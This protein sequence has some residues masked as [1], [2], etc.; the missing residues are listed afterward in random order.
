MEDANKIKFA[1]YLQDWNFFTGEKALLKRH[2]RRIPPLD[3]SIEMKGALFCPECSAPLFR[4]PESRDYDTSGR[5][6]FFAHGRGVSTRCS[7]RVEQRVGKRYENEEEA[8]QAIENEELVIVHALMRDKPEAPEIDGPVTYDREP[9]EDENGPLSQVSIARHNGDLFML[10]SKIT[11]IR[12]LCRRF[13]E[14]L[15]KYVLFPGQSSA[16]TLR[17][18]LT[19][20]KSVEGVC[21]EPRLYFGRITNS[22][23]M[24][25]SP[26]NI[27]MTYF[28]FPRGEFRDFCLKATDE[29]SQEHGISDDSVGKVVVAFGRVTENGIGLCLNNLGWGEFCVLPEQY[30]WLLSDG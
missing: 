19:S 8:R 17:Q 10:P 24:G 15:Y 26:Q 9:N 6:A 1:L 2:A 11:T 13:D 3:F 7:L 16:K 27:R 22:R 23:N 14:K 5:K 12:G 21:D 28:E 20:V 4:S 18:L 30:E 25:R 29:S